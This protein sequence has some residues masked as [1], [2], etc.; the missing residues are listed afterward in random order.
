M[1]TCGSGDTLIRHLVA[2]R[3][4]TPQM[5]ALSAQQTL[6]LSFSF[7]LSCFSFSIT[8]PPNPQFE[9]V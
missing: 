4:T 8:K 6:S 7:D 3:Q 1:S 2:S 5:K 9:Y